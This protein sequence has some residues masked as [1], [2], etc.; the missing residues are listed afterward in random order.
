V[1]L[2]LGSE[3]GSLR[4][5][6]KKG[7]GREKIMKHLFIRHMVTSQAFNDATPEERKKFFEEFGRFAKEQGCPLIFYGNPWGV[8]ESL[9]VVHESDHSLDHFIMFNRA[10]SQRLRQL[11]WK[12]YGATA[13]TITVTALE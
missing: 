10:W 11:G 2:N 12:G 3:V 1:E 13:T 5:T 4:S 6:K 7:H 9:T 8:P